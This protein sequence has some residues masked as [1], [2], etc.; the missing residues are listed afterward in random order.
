MA[1]IRK[2]PAWD[3]LLKRMRVKDDPD[4]L[5]T[6]HKLLETFL[7]EE[8]ANRAA[9]LPRTI[10]TG[11]KGQVW[12]AMPNAELAQNFAD[13]IGDVAASHW[14][15]H[16]KLEQTFTTHLNAPPGY[17]TDWSIDKLKLACILRCADAANIDQSRAPGFL[18]ALQQGRINS[19]SN[20][21]WTF[22]T[23]L[24]PAKRESDALR[25]SANAKFTKD[26]AE[27]WWLAYDTMAMLHGELQACDQLLYRR[28]GEK[29]RLA[30]R[31]VLD[32]D[33]PMAVARQIETEGW[34]PVDTAY[35]IADIPKLIEKLGG[36]QLYGN[37]LFVPLRE[38]I[39]NGMDAVRARR[40]MQNQDLP[41]LAVTLRIN[42]YDEGCTIVI[43]D[44]GCGM[45]GDQMINN[46]LG[47]G[48][49]G[50]TGESGIEGHDPLADEDV[51]GQYGI[52]FFSVFM[53][54]SNVK[55]TSLRLGAAWN[56]TKVLEF[57]KGLKERPV[58]FPADPGS[59]LQAAGTRIEI[60][61]DRTFEQKDF[62]QKQNWTALE[63]LGA[64]IP[65]SDVALQV[66]T[67]EGEGIVDGRN[68]QI[69]PAGVF[70]KRIY[71]GFSIRADVEE[72]LEQ[73]VQPILNGDGVVVGRA[74][75]MKSLGWVGAVSQ[76]VVVSRGAIVGK[77]GKWAGVCPG[78]PSRAS[79]DAATPL[80]DNIE[81]IDWLE[82]Q[83]DTMEQFVGPEEL[84]F[85]EMTRCAFGLET[86]GY[87]VFGFS[88][89][90]FT[91]K[92][93][94]EH[95]KD[96]SFFT[97]DL[98][99]LN[100]TVSGNEIPEL[101]FEPDWFDFWKPGNFRNSSVLTD[102]LPNSL[103]PDSEKV[104]SIDEVLQD[105]GISVDNLED[106]SM[107]YGEAVVEDGVNQF[108]QPTYVRIPILK[109]GINDEEYRLLNARDDSR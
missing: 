102:S 36:A 105:L 61:L 66:K 83:L 4:D 50:W 28:G 62:F 98:E 89:D 53:L 7:R 76:G 54:S 95:L 108:D 21:H 19:Y 41:D 60:V 64:E 15:S 6:Q 100:E 35:S 65:T 88:F 10:W 106:W 93:L 92:E 56:E 8:H 68:W 87:P 69:E 38:L 17:P 84:A 20:Q 47:F 2:M 82:N 46:L 42:G 27:T 51:S 37:D 16:E 13:V 74:V 72:R 18:Y 79:R 11:D 90:W 12:P 32:I 97:Y 39:M 81:Y 1:E 52:G 33:A 24:M 107:K 73:L 67:P 40:K 71:P 48:T 43:E 75:A 80:T 22:Q 103:L 63:K 14:W 30:A 26:E 29:A 99:G 49:S 109:F 31:R 85:C 91:R 104:P 101:T 3:K 78:F 5:P 25:F 86:R 59:Q 45:T 23:R 77:A 58:L 34:T 94:V 55:V 70:L 9:T 44:E 57:H 96:G